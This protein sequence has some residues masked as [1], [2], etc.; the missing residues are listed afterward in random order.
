MGYPVT[1]GAGLYDGA[2]QRRRTLP[3]VV[4]ALVA[5]DL[6]F[7]SGASNYLASPQSRI[8]NQLLI[9]GTV[10]ATGAAAWRGAIDLRSPLLL[11]GAA[12][13][14]A[15]G[16]AAVTSQ[17]PEASR[18]ALA[19]LLIS[20]PA[21]LA[22]RAILGDPW[23][24][25]RLDGLLVLATFGF[26]VAYLLQA[27]TQ[28]MAWWSV[29]GP[30]V[31]PLRP[32]DVGLTIGTVNSIALY[33]ET[34][35]PVALWLAWRRWRSRRMVGAF[36][37][38]SLV[39]LIVTGSRGAWLGAVA[40]LVALAVVVWASGERV[41]P[42]TLRIG[43][44]PGLVAAAVALVGAVVFGPILL[45]RLAGGDAGRF[46]LWDAAWSI[47]TA[48]PLTGAGPGAWQGLRALT[49][50]SQT[51]LAVLFT[52]HDSVLQIL[53][54]I[55][56]VGLLA[57][58]W[59]VAAIAFVGWRSVRAA[60]ERD[61]R[62]L[63]GIAL[64]TLVAFAVHSLVDTQMH[65]PAVVLLVFLL[66]ARLDA[67]G[68]APST[69]RATGTHRWLLGAAAPVVLGAVLLVPID[70]AMVRGALANT[71]L[72]RGDA[73]GALA[74]F[75][76]A[77][78]LHDLPV[79]RL[80]QALARAGTGDRT[81]ALAAL[82]RVDDRE[83]FTFVAA[84]RASLLDQMGA[85]ADA[86]PLLARVEAAGPYDP[87]ATLQVAIVRARQGSSLAI[88]D[89]AATM[90]G[91]PSLIHST[92]PAGLFDTAT[93]TAAQ[94]AAMAAMRPTDPA[95][96]AAEAIQAG[97]TDEAAKAR[98]LVTD[99]GQ[100]ELL[101]ILGMAV[102]GGSPDL[103]RARAI[104]R[105]DTGSLAVE[106]LVWSIG[107]AARSQPDIDAVA[108]AATALYFGPPQ[109]PMEI[110]LNGRLTADWSLRLLRYPMAA[111]ARLGPDRPYL[112]GA[113]TIEPVYRPKP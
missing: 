112:P 52:A 100:L 23:W 48:H 78:A 97:L 68:P 98:A 111:S 50:I 79:Y 103:D 12:W 107:F 2:V 43:R 54:E 13:V 55:G 85:A 51:N 76:G 96:A 37:A 113:A 86:G 22:V 14:A 102:A 101:D 29:A 71:A 65:V 15:T 36:T 49:P 45:T 6:I 31:P 83:P 41:V 42:R 75:D 109:P 9:L 106:E 11:P 34:L 4:V 93:W 39:A 27:F 32:G 16:L 92:P 81:G 110:V 66:V 74:G 38:L 77:I 18:E 3:W 20:A 8:L 64:A 30:S 88:D 19:L 108:R 63:R 62:V 58:V 1:R 21:Y 89:L 84:A 57:A 61:E 69:E 67:A 47:F 7:F 91:V 28:W 82:E 40:G 72:A 5:I 94:R 53:A 56:I 95:L 25:S 35:V 104:L 87:T 59:L 70:I 73:A 90:L 105:A 99:R 60:A 26:V 24:R 46:E 17:R 33:L 80:G 10:V 44:A